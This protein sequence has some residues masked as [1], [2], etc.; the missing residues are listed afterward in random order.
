MTTT[1]AVLFSAIG[2]GMGDVGKFAVMHALQRKGVTVRPVAL[3]WKEPYVQ[4]VSLDVVHT[5]I[6]CVS[7]W[8]QSL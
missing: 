5:P 2:S 7:R 4:S 8:D 1:I 6:T 3:S